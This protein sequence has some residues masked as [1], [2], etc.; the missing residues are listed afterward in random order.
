MDLAVENLEKSLNLYE[1]IKSF[2]I[3]SEY[4][5]IF[6]NL[7]RISIDENSPQGAKEYFHHFQKL[8]EENKLS[9][10]FWLFKLSKARILK[11]STRT[12]NRAEAEKLLLELIE[13][14]EAIKKSLNRGM[15]EEWTPTLIELCDFY[16]E[17]LRLTNDLEILDNI[18]PLILRLLKESERTNSYSLQAQ[19]YLLQGKISLIIFKM[20]EARRFLTQAE[21][22]AETHGLVQLVTEISSLH[23]EIMQQLEMWDNLEEINAPFSKRMELAH[24]GKNLAKSIRSRLVK[25]AQVSEKSITVYKEQ[26][27]CLV[28]KGNIEG[29]NKYIC[30][31]CDSVYCEHCARAL[32][33]IEN[34]CWSCESP[35]DKSKPV[36]FLKQEGKSI[37][38]KKEKVKK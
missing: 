26:K 17:K 36:K 8:V 29:F 19:T 5:L 13:Q 32:I 1:S 6:D 31:H 15:S 2:L 21:R 20:K 3:P 25:V 4:G 22:I 14:H 23:K 9:K 18:Q 34:V 10:E 35:I 38:I 27:K 33:D 7:I 28:C 12:R 37:K 11:L 16:V 24:L 30:S